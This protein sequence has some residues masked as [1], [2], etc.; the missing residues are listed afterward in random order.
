MNKILKYIKNGV[1]F[2][3]LWYHIFVTWKFY[4]LY[5]L[6]S[7]FDKVKNNKIVFCN[8]FGAGYGDNAKY[9]TEYIIR[10]KLNF[11]LVWLVNRRRCSNYDDFPKSVRIVDLYSFRAMK[12]LSSAR[13][14]IDNSRKFFFP[15]KKTNQIYIQTWHGM[16]P[17]KKIEKDAVNLPKYYVSAAK[18]DSKIM[19]AALSGCEYQSEIYRKSFWYDGEILNIGTPRVDIFFNIDHETVKKK[20]T[21]FCR[22]TERSK[23]VLYAPTFRTDCNL[24]VYN[25]DYELVLNTIKKRF[26]DEWKFA[27]RLH[28]NLIEKVSDL[29][30]PEFVL[31]VTKYPD[32]QEL[33]CASDLVI[34]DVS[35][36]MFDFCLSK[37]PVFLYINDYEDYI[38]K[39]RDLTMSPLDLPFPFA[40]NNE[41]L[42]NNISKFDESNYLHN[43][44]IFWNKIGLYEN[45]K[46]CENIIKF[47]NN[48]EIKNAK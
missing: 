29:K 22:I 34:T 11:E 10:N 15:N 7:C 45:G 31:D 16:L 19:D 38:T 17:L 46:C 3:H 41:L 48:F 25:I 13:I 28:P 24:N 20:I 30:I 5:N 23:I 12:E 8:Y 14:W 6:I 27:I 40:T 1:F 9:L 39:E 21:S 35:S 37:R 36:L 44:E 47:I 4:K 18:N 32:M 26:G 42:C 43:L 2:Y 33:L